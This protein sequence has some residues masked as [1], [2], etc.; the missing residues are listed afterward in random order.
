MTFPFVMG[1]PSYGPL[2]KPVIG[3]SKDCKWPRLF[4]YWLDR[5]NIFGELAGLVIPL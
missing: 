3:I 1:I 2:G 4:V 5:S